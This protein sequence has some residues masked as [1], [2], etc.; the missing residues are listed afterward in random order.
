MI[1]APVWNPTW[2]EAGVLTQ[3]TISTGAAEN[4]SHQ[5]P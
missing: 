1:E 2:P 4:G 3:A 5:R